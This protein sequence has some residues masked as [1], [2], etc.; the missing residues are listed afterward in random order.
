MANKIKCANCI[1]A[2][3]DKQASE[4][5]WTAY[6]CGNSK[7]EFYHALLNVTANGGKQGQITW[8][9]CELGEEAEET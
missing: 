8:R 5:N 2:R 3:V 7:S 9:G 6:E 1:Y 4:R